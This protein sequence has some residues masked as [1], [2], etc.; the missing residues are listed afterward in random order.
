MWGFFP[1]DALWRA[2]LAVVPLAL[3]VTLVCRSLPRR[4]A[5]RHS[6]WLMVIVWLVAAPLLPSLDLATTLA[7]GPEAT[8]SGVQHES[9]QTP[10]AYSGSLLTET[11]SKPGNPRGLNPA[12][13][14]AI[15]RNAPD[16]VDE[17][18]TNL[19]VRTEPAES[20]TSAKLAV[21]SPESIADTEP[22]DFTPP[23][24]PR[25]PARKKQ[26]DHYAH[27]NDGQDSRRVPLDVVESSAQALRSEGLRQPP[28]NPGIEPS[29]PAPAVPLVTSGCESD[30]KH[31]VA[32]P[33]PC[34]PPVSV[35][36]EKTPEAASK[37]LTMPSTSQAPPGAWR[38]PKRNS[39]AAAR[40]FAGAEAP[41]QGGPV[42]R[43]GNDTASPPAAPGAARA[44]PVAELNLD[45]GPSPR[46]VIPTRT[47]VWLSALVGVRDALGKLPPLP[48]PVWVL[49]I[50]LLAL[51]KLGS[52]LRF[53]RRLKLAYPAPEPA[54]R[55][56]A[57]TARQ[58]K[59]KR[60]PVTRMLDA[61][62]S[63]MVWL[64]RRPMLL[65]PR[66][67]WSQLDDASRRAV[68]CHELA[69]LRRLDH[70]VCWAET[71]IGWLYWWHPMVWWVRRQLHTEA[72]LS[73]DAWVTWLMPRART[74][75]A[76]ALLHTKCFVGKERSLPPLGFGMARGRAAKFGRRLKMIMTQRSRP[77]QS[78]FGLT[79][80]FALAVVGWVAVPAQSGPPEQAGG[81]SHAETGGGERDAS[82]DQRVERLEER[83][84]KLT[85]V[86]EEL[87]RNLDPGGSPAHKRTPK[88]KREKA[89]KREQ[90]AVRVPLPAPA[91]TPP[92]PPTK[93]LLKG[94]LQPMPPV[95]PAPPEPRI[96]A[97]GSAGTQKTVVHS[98]GLS[99]KKLERLGE[100]MLRSDVPVPV[101]LR[102][103]AIEVH[104][105][106]PQQSVFAGF[107]ELIHPEAE[108]PREVVAL[109]STDEGETVERSYRLPEDKLDDLYNL[110][111]LPDVPVVVSSDDGAITVYGTASQQ[112]VFKFFVELVD[113]GVAP[114]YPR[115]PEKAK[116]VYRDPAIRFETGTAPADRGEIQGLSYPL[117]EGK[118]EAL[119]GLMAL[120]D[121]PIVVSHEAEGIEVNGTPFQQS[122][123]A[124]FVRLIEPG[125]RLPGEVE[126]MQSSDAGPRM[127][128]D[129]E[130]PEHKLEAMWDLMSRSDVPIL[131]SQG[132][133]SISV[134]GTASQQSVFGAFVAMIHPEKGAQEVEVIDIRR[135]PQASTSETVARSYKLPPGKLEALTTLMIRG[136]VPVLVSP[137]GNE[138]VVHATPEQHEVFAAFVKLINP[139]DSPSGGTVEYYYG[140]KAAGASGAWVEA[141]LKAD[142]IRKKAE[143]I[144]KEYQSRVKCGGATGKCP[145]SCS[146]KCAKTGVGGGSASVVAQ[147]EYLHKLA[148]EQQKHEHELK[149]E[150]SEHERKL[151]RLQDEHQRKLEREQLE[152]ERKAK[153]EQQQERKVQ[154]ELRKCKRE[155]R[156]E[157]REKQREAKDACDQPQAGA[158]TAQPA[159]RQVL[160]TGRDL[161]RRGVATLSA[162][163]DLQMMLEQ[164]GRSAGETAG[165]TCTE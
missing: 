16:A 29:L 140:G 71:L 159:Y 152:R 110:M 30:S 47:Q 116:T 19:R 36:V 14:D 143:S 49:G 67:L 98:Y 102:D 91:P 111:A 124:G 134:Q 145:P 94:L 39:P 48:T 61:A 128:R 114:P 57:E 17:H 11:G 41:A 81:R 32:A 160:D 40:K 101:A 56:V 15:A 78:V 162:N 44:T 97:L 127:E 103:D 148:Q 60:L 85:A 43:S 34:D 28:V 87:S 4:P 95:A 12:A 115:A 82:L 77:G 66:E 23:H 137:G 163:F 31:S 20:G 112:Q 155:L 9:E 118:R 5:V 72:E 8:A 122:I 147:T 158:G 35:A 133:T 18:N 46:E 27:A 25:A 144:A 58:L 135:A 93:K 54:A 126:A 21:R 86:L 10:S 153:Q 84:D 63:P 142:E 109:S 79:L 96:V 53:R 69:H 123:F 120:S 89:Q 107:V 42:Y 1:T 2:A 150:C 3:V 37:P 6:L 100:L 74:A 62:V 119:W 13:R 73:C 51:L 45:P 131:V 105:T 59:L 52:V 88:V 157:E 136:D 129:Y 99:G 80:V 92:T 50:A 65:L 64:G 125:A 108:L 7:P 164:A 139:K 130:L 24:P 154:R 151:Q 104:G 76:Q 70:W 26:P 165:T 161:L 90:V 38:L 113:S 138:L 117:P 146:S 141:Q 75:Y 83:L 22:T 132:G 156:K 106:L 68:V 55:L 121:V 33:E 149:Q